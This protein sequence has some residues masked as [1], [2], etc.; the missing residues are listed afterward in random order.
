MVNNVAR[1]KYTKGFEIK[2]LT[3]LII[4]NKKFTDGVSRKQAEQKWKNN[5]ENRSKIGNKPNRTNNNKMNLKPV[6]PQ[7]SEE[8]M[9]IRLE[10]ETKS[11]QKLVPPTPP[12]RQPLSP[13]QYSREISKSDLRNQRVI[14]EEQVNSEVEIKK[15][16]DGTEPLSIDLDIEPKKNRRFL[17]IF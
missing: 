11:Q 2:D 4:A 16:N 10:D 1:T 12:R 9:S 15:S 8:P 14:G 17:G 7:L 5:V 13:D 3:S 6:G